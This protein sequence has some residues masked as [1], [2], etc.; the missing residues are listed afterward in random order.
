MPVHH[1]RQE[2]QDCATAAAR[3]RQIEMEVERVR[4]A[5]QTG[6]GGVLRIHVQDIYM[7][8]LLVSALKRA[9]IA[10]SSG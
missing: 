4:V 7:K 1:L 8:A 9:G 6:K 3:Q 10:I 2:A 5:L